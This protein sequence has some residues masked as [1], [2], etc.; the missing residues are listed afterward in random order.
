MLTNLK[1][2]TQLQYEHDCKQCNPSYIPYVHKVV[3]TD[4][5]ANGLTK[6]VITWIK[7][8]GYQ[9]E[10]ISTQGTYIQGKTVGTGFYGVKQTKG[11]YIPGQGTKGSA[12]ISATLKGGLSVKIEIKMKDRQSDAQ[13]QY[14]SD[15]ERAGGQYWLVRSMDDFIDKWNL[16]MNK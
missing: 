5:T 15:I 4:K 9:A 2:L 16:I 12:D 8:H 3:F 7:L 14:Q 11:K 13:K 6:C 10:R 1:L